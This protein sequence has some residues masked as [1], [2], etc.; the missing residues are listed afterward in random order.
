MNVLFIMAD[1]LRWDHLGCA[2]H[3]YLKTPEHRRAGRARRA[4]RQRLRQ[5]RRLRPQPH[6]LLHRPLPH[7]PRRHLEPRAA[8]G[9]RGDAG[10]DA[11]RRRP[12]AGAGRQDPCDAR[13]R[14]AWR[15]CS[16]KAA[17]NW[18][19]AANAA[20]STR[21]TAT[22]AT[23]RRAPNRATRP[24]CAPTAT[25]ATTPGASTS[26]PASAPTARSRAAGT[27]ATCTC[28]R[29]CRRR[30]PKPPT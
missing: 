10:R 25:T 8:V 3:P 26:S 7:Q 18:P 23:T 14:T 4:L 29:A 27:C 2:G 1:Q 5:Q 17:A 12:H 9:G 24:S 19:P 20:A 6:E 11:A 21:S 13:P 16:S 22:T 15:G 30:I 28:R